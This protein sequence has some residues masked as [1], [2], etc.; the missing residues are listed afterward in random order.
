MA[1]QTPD[2][3]FETQFLPHLDA[4]YRAA[5]S[6]TRN[7]QDA[8]DLVQDTFLRAFQFIDKFQVGT[9]ARAWLFR[10]LTNLFINRYRRAK[11]EP[12]KTSYDEMEDFFLY[13]RLQDA[14]VSGKS[15]TPE[16]AVLNKVQ[17]E[18][19]HEAIGN[20]P[21]EYRETVILADV[22]ELSYL[23]I[24]EILEVPIGTVRS[25]LSRGRR[26]VQRALWAFTEENPR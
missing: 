1:K 6:M 10:I 15:D 8:D 22:N 19:I 5:L 13:N 24:S 25:R 3:L 11:R 4:L 7:P 20:L 23:E 12:E 16:A 2:E 21:D 26:L 9:N 17:A 18:A 14:Y